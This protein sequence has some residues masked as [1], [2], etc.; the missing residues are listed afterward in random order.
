MS[1][2]NLYTIGYSG[3][4]IDNFLLALKKYSI[5]ALV[6]VRTSPHSA[7]Y[8]I[9]NRENIKNILNR[10][11]ILYLFL[12]KELG[13]RPEDGALYTRHIADFKKISN[14]E[15]FIEACRRIR[16]G[17]EIFP[18][19]MM[20]AEKDPINCHRTVL[21]ANAFRNTY[22]E[23][24]ISHIHSDLKIESQDRIDRRIMALYDLEQEHL[25]KDYEMRKIEAY[26]LREKDIAFN[27]G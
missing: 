8:T 16:Q 26:S 9:Y 21:V 14:S 10:E 13:A 19:C 24:S 6:D 23:V 12:G 5:G 17:L 11:N 3:F 4:D 1:L 20:C 18:I 25:F 7:Y 2:Y 22:P 27:E 15:S